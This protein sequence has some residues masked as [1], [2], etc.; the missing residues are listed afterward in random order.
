VSIYDFAVRCSVAASESRAAEGKSD[1]AVWLVGEGLYEGWQEGVQPNAR[2]FRF[3]SPF[4]RCVR[5]GVAAFLA[6]P[7]I[8]DR[9]AVVATTKRVSG[10]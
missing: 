8:C 6:S 7:A 10:F 1:R 2:I 3:R 9:R 5:S 4:L